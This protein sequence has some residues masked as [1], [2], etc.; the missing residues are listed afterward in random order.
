MN[1]TA[2]ESLADNTGEKAGEKFVLAGRLDRLLAFVIDTLLAWVL[3]FPLMFLIVHFTVGF[4]ILDN[5]NHYDMDVRLWLA[6]QFLSIAICCALNGRLLARNGQTIGKKLFGMRIANM[7]GSVPEFW[8]QIIKRYFFAGVIPL[9]I[10]AW[11]IFRRDRRCGHDRYAGT[12]VV[13]CDGS[14]K[15]KEQPRKETPGGIQPETRRDRLP[16]FLKNPRVLQALVFWPIVV[17]MAVYYDDLS[18]MLRHMLEPKP[19]AEQV[20]SQSTQPPMQKTVQEPQ[21]PVQAIAGSRTGDT[22]TELVTGM[23]FVWIQGGCFRMGTSEEEKAE[24]EKKYSPRAFKDLFSNEFPQHEVCVDGFWMGKYEVTN[25]EFRKFRPEHNSGNAPVGSSPFDGIITIVT[26]DSPGRGPSLN[27]DRQ[28]VVRVTWTD[29]MAFAGWLSQKNRQNLR[30]PT[31]AEWEY[32][33]RAGTTTPYFWGTDPEKVC[34][35]ANVYDQTTAAVMKL[36]PAGFLCNDGHGVLAPVGSFAP[37]PWG[38]YDMVGNA[39]ERCLDRYAPDYYQYS[40]K[41]NPQ[42]P[43]Q[44][45]G[46]WVTRGFGLITDIYENLGSARRSYAGDH[47]SARLGFRLVMLGPDQ[48]GQHVSD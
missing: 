42:G 37:N 14:K 2:S 32:A 16:A 21:P 41:N 11:S 36:G 39:R 18:R 17:F 9:P 8:Y 27:G 46:D 5:Y 3:F 43:Q 23:E 47:I 35:Y 33:A 12:Q 38:L 44:R 6:G 13:Y 15:A 20:S 26:G 1:E 29:A 30:L 24:L 48:K 34:H 25:A 19:Y 22:W 31:E 4:E 28:P 40:P 45:H 10:D 7:E